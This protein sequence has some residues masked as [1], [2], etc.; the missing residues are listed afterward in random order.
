MCYPKKP[1]EIKH[2]RK[3]YK[4]I[5]KKNCKRL[6]IKMIYLNNQKIL[7]ILKRKKG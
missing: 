1:K 5:W 2:K 6:T 4:S 7:L 3:I